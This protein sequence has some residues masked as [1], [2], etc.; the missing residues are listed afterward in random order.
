METGLILDS[1][2]SSLLSLF[3]FLWCCRKKKRE[4]YIFI[5]DMV[6]I[7]IHQGCAK[8][9]CLINCKYFMYS[10]ILLSM[11][12]FPKLACV[13]EFHLTLI[14]WQLQNYDGNKYMYQEKIKLQFLMTLIPFLWWIIK[15]LCIYWCWRVQL[16]DV[17]NK[18]LR[19][20]NLEDFW[21]HTPINASLLIVI[22]LNFSQKHHAF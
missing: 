4:K 20:Q 13:S 2:F 15:C 6:L 7:P 3:G 8:T 16:F 22:L 9:V 14:L 18:F 12:P 5:K 17:A 10:S 19:G 1:Q 11:C 21:K